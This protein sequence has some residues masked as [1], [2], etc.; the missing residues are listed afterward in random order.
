MTLEMAAA[1]STDMVEALRQAV[2][3]VYDKHQVTIE[4][5][6]VYW[7]WTETGMTVKSIALDF[8]KEYPS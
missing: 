3:S 5:V 2:Q 1:P 8:Y 6:D 7:C 4:S